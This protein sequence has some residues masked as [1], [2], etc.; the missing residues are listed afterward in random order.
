MILNEAKEQHISPPHGF[1]ICSDFNYDSSLDK[2]YIRK[3]KFLVA[4]VR[5]CSLK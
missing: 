5:R 2:A 1:P 4:V 3:G